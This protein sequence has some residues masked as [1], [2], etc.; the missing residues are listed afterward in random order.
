MHEPPFLSPQVPPD[1]VLAAA[2]TVA[3]DVGDAGHERPTRSLRAWVR[4]WVRKLTS[5]IR[6]ERQARRG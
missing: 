5:T 1:H 2:A 6:G 3:D 4:T